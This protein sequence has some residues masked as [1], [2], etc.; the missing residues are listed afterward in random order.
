MSKAACITDQI[1]SCGKSHINRV[2]NLAQKHGFAT[3][4]KLHVSWMGFGNQPS[5]PTRSMFTSN[6]FIALLPYFPGKLSA[7]IKRWGYPHGSK[8]LKF[9]ADRFLK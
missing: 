8:V 1:G 2:S 3:A 4:E 6:H 9:L 5:H 7:E